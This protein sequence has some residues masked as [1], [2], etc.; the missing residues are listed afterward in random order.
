VLSTQDELC[1]GIHDRREN[2]GH[3][4]HALPVEIEGVAAHVVE[5]SCSETRFLTDFADC[6]VFGVLALFDASVNDLPGS[7]ATGAR[8]PLED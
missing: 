8:A 4:H 6:R 2:D 7:G 5:S 3:V 1:G